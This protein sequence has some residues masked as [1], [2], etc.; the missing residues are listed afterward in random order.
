MKIRNVDF[1]GKW[2]KFSD[3]CFFFLLFQVMDRFN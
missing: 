1:I 3:F 2:L